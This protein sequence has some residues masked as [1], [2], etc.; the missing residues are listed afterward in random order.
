MMIIVAQIFMFCA[1]QPSFAQNLTPVERPDD[2][3][4]ILGLEINGQSRSEGVFA[5]QPPSASPN[6]ILL[7]MQGMFDALS[8]AIDV[9]PLDGTAD[10]FFLREDRVFRLDIQQKKITLGSY[11]FPLP[12]DAVEV[13]VDDIYVNLKYLREWFNL[14]IDYEP[15]S[16]TLSI[17]SEEALP[18]QEQAERQARAEKN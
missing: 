1:V 13:H 18:F 5:Y 7:P 12:S 4:L 14:D 3:L 10:G 9:Q 15:T 16:L 11:E 2:E 6:E 8:A 17:K